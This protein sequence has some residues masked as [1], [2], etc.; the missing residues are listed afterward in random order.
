MLLRHILAAPEV[1]SSAVGPL[2][3]VPFVTRHPVDHREPP[4]ATDRWHPV[5]PPLP[6]VGDFV[7]ASIVAPL[8]APSPLVGAANREEVLAELV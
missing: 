5:N 1:A 2:V 3:P 4:A 8:P 6:A 7:H